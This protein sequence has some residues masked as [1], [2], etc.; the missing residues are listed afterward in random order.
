MMASATWS[1][2][3]NAWVCLV[4]DPE[5]DWT[6]VCVDGAWFHESVGLAITDVRTLRALDEAVA[7]HC[8]RGAN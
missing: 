7:D 2:S 3:T 4:S 5:G 6:A 8:A 1:P